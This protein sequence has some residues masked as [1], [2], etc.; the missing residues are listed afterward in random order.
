M[1]GHIRTL[2]KC[3]NCQGRFC[4]D[5][6]CPTCQTQPTRFFLDLWW[7]GRLKIYTG[8]D[9][10]PLDSRE[11]A[12]RLLNA[13]RHEIDLGKFDP[14]DYV[15]RELRALEFGNYARAWL[16]RR[17]KEAA[18]GHLSRAYLNLLRS[19]A[20]K[21]LIPHFGRRNLRDLREGDL[22]DFK[23]A[24]PTELSGKTVRNLLGVLRKLLGDAHRRRDL[25]RLPAFPSIPKSEPVTRWLPEEDQEQLLAHCREPYRSFFLFLMRTGC[26]PGEARA[27]KWDKVD[28]RNGVVT[29]AAAMD[30]NEWRPY[31]KARE[32]RYLP[33][34]PQ[35][36]AALQQLP[37]ALSGY[38]FINV[39]GRPLS[40]PRIHSAWTKAARKAGVK[41]TCYEGTR[42][43]LAS[44]A[45]QRGVSLYK[46]GRALGHKSLASTQRYAKLEA[47]A[48]REVM[49]TG[50][51]CNLSVSPKAKPE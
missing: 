33:M 26:R 13:I 47:E 39:L 48:L 42:H 9:G 25:P 20:A 10:Y 40:R 14:K 1:A 17:E 28:F 45:V 3:P 15:S 49:E 21:Y 4:Q 34:H 41:V 44:Q 36:R 11:R 51:V 19:Y 27:L 22:E 7:E 8:K 30:L 2:Q 43:S 6:T 46:V 12:E 31:T 37:R 24:L 23:N 29:I 35:V 32:V 5:L 18:R 50:T 38:V 16:Q